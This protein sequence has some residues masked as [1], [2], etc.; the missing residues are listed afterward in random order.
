M[1]RPLFFLLVALWTGL[2]FASTAGHAETTGTVQTDLLA[3]FESHSQDFPRPEAK[4]PPMPEGKKILIINLKHD[5]ASQMIDAKTAFYLTRAMQRVRQGDIGAVIL[6][7]DTPGG[8]TSHA[9]M[10]RDALLRMEP[11]VT[12]CYVRRAISAGSLLMLA[13][14]NIYVAP[15]ASL[16]D[17]QTIMMGPGGVTSGEGDEALFDKL[18]AAGRTEWEATAERKGHRTD[19][20]RA[21]ADRR[22]SVPGIVEE[23]RIL[24]MTGRQAVAA[25]L[26]IAE[27]N[28]VL[29]LAPMLGMAD[30]PIEVFELGKR[31]AFAFRIKSLSWLFL[32]LAVIGFYLEFS[33][34]GF[35]IPGGLALLSLVLFFW[36]SML[37][38]TA[39]WF[40]IGLFATGIIL[41]IIEVAVLPGFGVAGISGL[42]CILLSLFLAMFSLPDMSGGFDMALTLEHLERPLIHLFVMLAT[43]TV[44][45][46]LLL[47]YLPSSPVWRLLALD[48]AMTAATGHTSI[49]SQSQWIGHE[50]LAHSTLRPGG[51]IEI[52]GRRLDAMTQGDFITKGS[53]VRVVAEGGPQL[54][55]VAVDAAPQQKTGA[56]T[57]TGPA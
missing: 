18:S 43:L 32:A 2:C 53:R 9:F 36:A 29:D 19:I 50:G 1:H 52:D 57:P 25:R 55:V 56:Q 13:C 6:D 5:F 16:G 12:T 37:A 20:A 31:E 48:S 44:V 54:V 24:N 27:V 51:I 46:L 23:D 10:A 28:N 22:E 34:P 42:V 17:A 38:M 14:D 8:Y 35:G 11:V 49:P 15:G 33:N 7:M 3:R 26:A 40:E 4:L 39:S 21:F 30:A 45:G 47:R 41:L